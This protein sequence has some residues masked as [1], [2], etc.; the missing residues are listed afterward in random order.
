MKKI[1][2]TTLFIMAL[3]GLSLGQTTTTLTPNIGSATYSAQAITN[4]N[5]VTLL[6]SQNTAITSSVA[7]KS[8]Q[9]T[10]NQSLR[11]LNSLNSIQ[12][13]TLTIIKQKQDT[14]NQNLRS[15]RSILSSTTATAANQT[16]QINYL[17][18]LNRNNHVITYT[19]TAV[20]SNTGTAYANGKVVMNNTLSPTCYTFSIP[21]GDYEVMDFNY[22]TVGVV[23]IKLIFIAFTNTV[24]FGTDNSYWAANTSDLDLLAFHGAVQGTNPYLF[25]SNGPLF[26]Q[27]SVGYCPNGGAIATLNRQVF[28]VSNGF[29]A[30]GIFAG[31]TATPNSNATYRFNL[32][33]RKIR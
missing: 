26:Y 8:G 24:N 10:L 17:D 20:S 2:L 14:I 3:V 23:D 7:T 21:N 30:Y 6:S 28:R 19:F 27:I 22:T 32:K 18:S 13:N 15:V 16:T 31:T 9:D 25:A 12:N 4:N 29:L 1:I 5:I 11:F 33:L